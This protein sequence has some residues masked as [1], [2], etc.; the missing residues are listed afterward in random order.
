MAEAK[1]GHDWNPPRVQ[2]EIEDDAQT[3]KNAQRPEIMDM[4]V[5]PEKSLEQLFEVCHPFSMAKV[6]YSTAVEKEL[7][8]VYV[9]QQD[10]LDEVIDLSHHKAPQRLSWSKDL[11]DHEWDLWHGGLLSS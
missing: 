2:K 5:L 6:Q 9:A 7:R 10:G 11:E 1:W 8:L 3:M 4:L